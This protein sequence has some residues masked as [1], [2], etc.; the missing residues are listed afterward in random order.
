MTH[1]DIWAACLH[2]IFNRV[3][4]GAP[5]ALP[6]MGCLVDGGAELG[7]VIVGGDVVPAVVDKYNAKPSGAGEGILHFDAVFFTDKDIL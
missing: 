7:E 5:A 6:A 3:A 2:R 4:V 1:R